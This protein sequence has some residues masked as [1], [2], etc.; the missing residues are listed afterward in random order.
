MTLPIHRTDREHKKFFETGDGKVGVRTGGS[1]TMLDGIVFDEIQ[2]AYPT[3][4]TEI[5]TYSLDGSQVAIVTVTYSNASKNQVL[6]VVR[7]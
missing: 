2:A 5:Y 6:S 1:G 7:T 4:T 3:S